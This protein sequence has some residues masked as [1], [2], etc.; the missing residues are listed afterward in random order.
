MN[1]K[2]NSEYPLNLFKYFDDYF[3]KM[4]DES[5]D[6]KCLVLDQETTGLSSIIIN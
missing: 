5:K 6:L 3:E 2:K 4:I 1:T